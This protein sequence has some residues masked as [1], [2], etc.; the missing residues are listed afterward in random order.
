VG[1]ALW[2]QAQAEWLGVAGRDR[3][4][5]PDKVTSSHKRVYG[6]L[7]ESVIEHL[8]EVSEARSCTEIEDHFKRNYNIEGSTTACE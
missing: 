5:R 1:N 7:S 4:L 3:P 6:Q 8:A 2:Q